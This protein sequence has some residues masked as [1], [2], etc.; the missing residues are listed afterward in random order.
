MRST[1]HHVGDR[2][3]GNDYRVT[4]EEREH[5]RDCGFV[6]LRRLLTDDEISELEVV[7]DRFLR[8]E[9]EVPGKDYCDMAGDYG[10]LHYRSIYLVPG[11]SPRAQAV[12]I[13]KAG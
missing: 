8:R 1:L 12:E 13:A 4:D 3:N 11:H 5:F 10:Q 7:Y 6:H 2:I 9:I